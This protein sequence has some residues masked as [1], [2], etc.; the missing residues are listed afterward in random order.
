MILSLPEVDEHGVEFGGEVTFK[1]KDLT[2][3]K[4]MDRWHID[5]NGDERRETRVLVEGCCT[6]IFGRDEYNVKANYDDMV[7]KFKE[8]NEMF[9]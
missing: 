5:R 9:A 2:A 4:K 8:Q 3:I 6:V 7:A 1:F